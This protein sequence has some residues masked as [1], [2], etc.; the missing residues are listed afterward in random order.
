VTNFIARNRTFV[1]PL[2]GNAK[3]GIMGDSTGSNMAQSVANTLTNST[4]S[5]QVLFYGTFVPANVITQSRSNFTNIQYLILP[6]FFTSSEF[7][8]LGFFGYFGFNN[9]KNDKRY[10]T[11]RGVTARTPKALMILSELDPCRNDSDILLAQAF[12]KAKVNY[13]IRVVQGMVHGFFG[14][15]HICR[16][17]FTQSVAWLRDFLREFVLP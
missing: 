14:N 7:S 15:G 12:D 4:L 5:F 13:T 2:A 10:Y 16:N 3:I 11:T 17:A 9:L 6:I 1:H 8:Y